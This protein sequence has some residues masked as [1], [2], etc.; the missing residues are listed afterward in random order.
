VHD[1]RGT[2]LDCMFATFEFNTKNKPDII[3]WNYYVIF[4]VGMR[5][6]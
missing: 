2:H 6:E 4:K 5:F 3:P 1:K